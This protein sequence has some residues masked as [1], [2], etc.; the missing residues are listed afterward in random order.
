MPARGVSPP[1]CALKVA[2]PPESQTPP[3]PLQPSEGAAN[4]P[5]TTLKWVIKPPT[6]ASCF[7]QKLFCCRVCSA[8]PGPLGL[9]CRLG[10]A[11]SRTSE[12]RRLFRAG[13]LSPRCLRNAFRLQRVP[14]PPRRE[15]ARLALRL[16]PR[17]WVFLCLSVLKNASFSIFSPCTAAAAVQTSRNPVSES[18]GPRSGANSLQILGKG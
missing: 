3:S 5:G 17:F 1:N 14:F 4:S 16:A 6:E 10:R 8:G 15:T 12:N 13:P 9:R 2:K 7:C 11:R 18:W